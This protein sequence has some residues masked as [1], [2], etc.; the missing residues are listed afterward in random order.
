MMLGR[1][2]QVTVT[3]ARP[4]VAPSPALSQLSR[5]VCLHTGQ[6]TP[7]SLFA[8]LM[9]RESCHGQLVPIRHTTSPLT[10]SQS[11]CT[12]AEWNLFNL[13]FG[14]YHPAFF[15]KQHFIPRFLNSDSIKLDTYGKVGKLTIVIFSPKYKVAP[16]GWL[17][18]R[19]SCDSR[20]NAFERDSV[21]FPHSCLQ[22]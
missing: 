20:R 9:G 2:P 10:L 14:F 8:G 11:V 22:I 18:T 7:H 16:H 21:P 1:F 17:K 4:R 13:G 3:Q 6:I 15:F 5:T 12:K 19:L